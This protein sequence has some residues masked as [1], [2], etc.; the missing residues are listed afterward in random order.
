MN[1]EAYNRS[2]Q[3]II[4]EGKKEKR[5]RKREN[6][7][8]VSCGKTSQFNIYGVVVPEKRGLVS[9]KIFE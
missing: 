3:Q 1:P 4:T 8:S 2:Y 9:E 6:G 5:V 7:T